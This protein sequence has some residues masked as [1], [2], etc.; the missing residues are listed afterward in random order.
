MKWIKPTYHWC[1]RIF[2]YTVV[3]LI[4]TLAIS[5]SLFRLYLPDVKA[6]RVD[7]EL[8]ASELLDQDVRI[9][10]MDAKLSGI[11]P[12][13]VF[14]DVYLLDTHSKNEIVHFEQARLTIDIFRSLL[15]MEVVPESFTI[16]GVDLGVKRKADGS[17]TILG[18][19]IDELG[20]QIPLT[21]NDE[22][23]DELATW[24]FKRSKLA[25]KNSRVVFQDEKTRY[26]NK[27]NK[28]ENVNLYLKN[29]GDRHQLNGTI[30]L[31]EEL[32]RDLEVAFDF[33]G[34]IL[35]PAEWYGK[36]FYKATA[37]NLVNLGV[38]PEF[39]HT[40][41]EQGTID[42]SLWGDWKRGVI[43]SFTADLKAHDF[44]LNLGAKAKPFSM[45]KI[46]GLIDWHADDIGWKLNVRNFQYQRDKELWPL[47]SIAVRYV[48]DQK[49]ITAYSSFLRLDDIKQV[50]IDSR[51]LDE[52]L[53]S[54][55][56]KLDP[57]GDLQ[58]VYVGYSFDDSFGQFSLASEFKD[59]TVQPWEQ[60][61]GIENVTGKVWLDKNKGRFELE[62][63]QARLHIPG[64]FRK[65]FQLTSIQG[66]ID[67]YRENKRW[68]VNS[69]EFVAVSPDIS[70]DLGF[71][72][73]VP[74]TGSSPYLD[75][76]VSYKNG[77]AKQANKYYPVSIMDEDLIEWLDNAFKSGEVV[78]GGVI[79]NGR[80][81]DFP[82]R[83]REGTLLADF[84]T[85]DVELHYQPGWP[86]IKV[87][88][89]DLEVT[90]L[91]LSVS[92]NK[93][94]LYNSVLSDVKVS[95][96]SFDSPIL[97]AS[98]RLH[99]RTREIAKFLV[100]SPI[101]PEA[102]TIL[103]QSRIL[104]KASG[105]GTLQLPLS[106][107]AEQ[108]APL[109]YEANV[110]IQGNELNLWQGLLV[111]KKI[112]G[113]LKV[114]PKGVFSNNLFFNVLGGQSKA[115]LYTT[116]VDG[117][118]NIKLSMLGEIDAGRIKEHVPLTLLT[119][120]KGKTNWQGIMALGND[121]SPGYFQF[122][123]D[124][125][126]VDLKLPAPLEKVADSQRSFNVTVQFPEKDKLP[127]NFKYGNELSGA[128]VINM[129]NPEQRPI[130]KGELIFSSTDK[131]TKAVQN[132]PQLPEYNELLIR[133]HLSEFRMD[134]WLQLI[135]KDIEKQDVNLMSLNIPLKLDMEYLKVITNVED[136]GETERKDPRKIAL[137][138]GD[139]KTLVIN[140]IQFGHVKFKMTRHED[141]LL[142]RDLLVD[143]PY[144]HVEGEGSWFFR[145]GRHTTNLLTL[146][147]SGDLGE[148]L[149][150]L[151]Y[152][153]VM[154][155]G[156][157]KAVLQ[158]NWHDT[159]DRFSMEKLN[160]SLG[161]VIDDGVLSD[162]KPGAGRMLGLFS[163]AELPRRLVL[164]FS[165]L[166]EGFAFK[167]I[168]GQIDIRDGDAFTETLK[169]IS[170]IAL[171]KIEG[172]TGLASRD[173]DQHVMVAPSLS[174]TLPV[175][176]WLAW[177]GQVGALAFLLDQMFGDQFDSS[178][179]TE[180]EITGSWDDPQILK[181]KK[182][183]P[184]ESLNE[185]DE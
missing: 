14:E 72:A 177:G 129:K 126:G 20:K 80:F 151:G 77:D 145:D 38:K 69:N 1:K 110:A 179:A 100:E 161:V 164:D 130:E 114:N 102:K 66:K 178:V 175:I 43:T 156:T 42:V 24:F 3:G 60:F 166:K 138:D 75:L 163:L 13:I 134:E 119:N 79:F 173:F 150:R 124:L 15:K 82:F 169:I 174:G 160:G 56:V 58:E 22:E 142:L 36:V 95:I 16:V 172:R 116:N 94:R 91:G 98:S 4:I 31:P 11:T 39:M 26:K 51:L 37:L 152:S 153:A 71:Y 17:F 146:I 40:S 123:S 47:S 52:A 96:E 171:I 107:S 168:V 141:G 67:W 148:M 105:D 85:K 48:T 108:I 112:N 158:A 93:S 74:E 2:W 136:S 120:I 128:L 54:N 63:K 125:K 101:A 62:S 182:E 143:A 44:I 147:S 84:R 68:H 35:N 88:E 111:A 117:R 139:I 183:I 176:S 28:F 121:E 70:A 5:I 46:S 157:T 87:D 45:R 33:N 162:V 90:G 53:Q 78:S 149:T 59:L 115:K 73:M 9:E 81:Q 55:L 30:T 122:V 104:G 27:F 19:G 8:F 61:P 106:K 144:M 25:I 118:Q 109:N 155:K 103:N 34:N 23:S 132:E 64:M 12:L 89:A 99:G 133:G 154:Q 184:E 140:D 7:I 135:N 49:H 18:L 21:T 159:P 167:Q 113:E 86:S 185:E 50:L 76:Q 92:S 137:F 170:P 10:S 97:H 65:P 131:T 41:L 57:S 6:Y 29:D 32:G 127:V 165:E 83:K 180:Y 181:I